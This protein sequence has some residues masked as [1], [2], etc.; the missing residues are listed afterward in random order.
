MLR[1]EIRFAEIVVFVNRCDVF[2]RKHVSQ[3][4]IR[5]MLTSEWLASV[6]HQPLKHLR[7]T[8]YTVGGTQ[9]GFCGV[10]Q[11]KKSFTFPGHY[12]IGVALRS[13]HWDR[14]STAE[15]LAEDPSRLV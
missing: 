10:G 3:E 4:L 13:P 12:L 15:E 8:V 11:G 14:F 1:S 9:I 5:Q 2:C 7:T 6:N